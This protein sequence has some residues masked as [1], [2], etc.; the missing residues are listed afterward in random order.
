MAAVMAVLTPVRTFAADG[1]YV[2]DV[3]VYQAGSFEEAKA[4][5]SS[6]GYEIVE[7]NLNETLSTGLYLGYKT[8]ADPNEALTDI[9]AMNMNGNYSYSDYDELMKKHR[10]KVIETV[11]NFEQAIAE[12]QT[13]FANG[14]AEAQMAYDSLNLFRDDDSGALMGDY[15]L[16]FDFSSAME[17]QFVNML[18]QANSDIVLTMM[19]NVAMASDAEEGSMLERFAKSSPADVLDRYMSMGAYLSVAQAQQAMEADLSG[20][21]GQIRLWWDDLYVYLNEVAQKRFIRNEDGSYTQRED[22][23]AVSAGVNTDAVPGLSADEINYIEDV[24]T[25]TEM[26]QLDRAYEDVAFFTLL[27]GLKFKDEST[28]L[29]DFFM[30]PASEVSDEELYPVAD[31]MSRGQRAQLEFLGLHT[32]LLGAGIDLEEGAAESEEAIEQTEADK[33]EQEVIS[34]Y[35]DVDRSVFEDGVA[36]TGSAVQHEQQSGK[37]AFASLM[38]LEMTKAQMGLGILY[39]SVAAVGTMAAGIVATVVQYKRMNA[40]EPSFSYT[41]NLERLNAAKDD[42]KQAREALKQAKLELKQLSEFADVEP[43][44]RM[45]AESMVLVRESS[46]ET[47]TQVLEEVTQEFEEWAEPYNAQRAEAGAT[48]GTVKCISF[49]MF[50]IALLL[51]IYFVVMYCTMDEPAEEKIPHHLLAAINTEYGEDYVYYAAVKDQNGAAA[52]INNHEGDKSIGW[53]V[54]YKTQE[55]NAGNPILASDLRVQT[56]SHDVKEGSAYI[57]LFDQAGAVSLSDPNY[58][59]KSDSAGGVY[60]LFERDANAFAGSAITGGILA[61]TAAGGLI[62]GLGGGYLLGNSRKKKKVQA[63]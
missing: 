10:N 40:I 45:S 48:A 9:A 23:F 29:L 44:D 31:A 3:M 59:G 57:H 12:F 39:S 5:L 25:L 34:I 58:T 55:R 36:L 56:G 46:V 14:K 38:G 21:V 11:K 6:L 41:W 42:L 32:I 22:A 16:D 28:T 20:T 7:G 1:K 51:D 15:L 8:T 61:I 24:T 63:A 19:Q 35:L 62:L 50:A 53:L 2:S 37:S 33:A 52:D 18:L 13:N 47:R 27:S 54:L 17:E 60:V 49:I 4:G 43:F 26:V 30:R